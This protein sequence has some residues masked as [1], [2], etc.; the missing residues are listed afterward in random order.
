[1]NPRIGN[2]PGLQMVVGGQ[3]IKTQNVF[4]SSGDRAVDEIQLV[5]D[6]DQ[7]E[8]SSGSFAWATKTLGSGQVIFFDMSGLPVLGDTI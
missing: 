6:I 2:D 1:M 8:P 7:V 3:H 4:N 5:G